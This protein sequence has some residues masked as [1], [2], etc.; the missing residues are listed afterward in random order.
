MALK[1]VVQPAN[2][3]KPAGVWTPAIVVNNPGKL[4]FLS[5]FTARDENGKV[6]HAGDM[7]SQT[8]LVCENLKA[9]VEA[10]GGTLADL[11]SVTVFVTDIEQFDTIHEVRR[12]YFPKE[13]PSSTMVEV[14][15]LVHKDM[16]IEINAVAALP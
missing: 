2:V 10:A 9:T 12:Q 6:V 5:G 4:V 15:R 8:R 14:T 11:V 13:P 16:L 1:Q 7:R 3:A